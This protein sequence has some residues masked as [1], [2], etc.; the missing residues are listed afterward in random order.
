MGAVW[1]G[2]GMVCVGDRR[3]VGKGVRLGR[4]QQACPRQDERISTMKIFFEREPMSGRAASERDGRRW[5]TIIASFT[6]T[7]LQPSCEL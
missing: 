4:L 7:V 6:T 2:K 5:P 3:A 1:Q